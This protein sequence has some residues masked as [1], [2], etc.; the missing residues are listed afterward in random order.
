MGHSDVPGIRRSEQVGAVDCGW[1]CP[2]MPSGLC[3]VGRHNGGRIRAGSSTVYSP[4]QG[5]CP[6]APRAELVPVW[7]TASSL[8]LEHSGS[9]QALDRFVEQINE[10]WLLR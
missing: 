8:S 10:L 2:Y 6:P 9:Q 5:P 1:A 4:G 3:L 7:I